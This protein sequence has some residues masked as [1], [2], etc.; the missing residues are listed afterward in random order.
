M[1]GSTLAG[2][3]SGLTPNFV[4][5]ALSATSITNSLIFDNGTN[6]GI[7]S[8]APGAALDVNGVISAGGSGSSYFSSG[9]LGVGT[10][11]P[12]AA[13]VVTGG[14]VGIGTW[15]AANLLSIV[16]GASIGS[17]TYANTTAPANGLLVSGNVGIGSLAPGQLLDV[18]GTTRTAFFTLSGN[19]AAAGN[20]MVSNAV[21]MGTWM[22]ASTLPISGAA[23]TNYW[24]LDIGNVGI[25]T[26]NNI[27]IGTISAV[28]SLNILGNVGVGTISYSNYLKL[29]PPPAAVRFLKV[30]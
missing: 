23:G 4:T 15:T 13:F 27:G 16:G 18:Q 7:G 20:V 21:G 30:T 28:N 25:N 22:A 29:K 2:T 8:V 17:A 6:V 14:N 26:S 10:I 1:A 19:G 5:K 3:I 24:T 12:Q 9:N 11:N